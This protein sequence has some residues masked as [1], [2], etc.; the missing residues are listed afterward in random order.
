MIHSVNPVKC[1]PASGSHRDESG[2][3]AQSNLITF[4]TEFFV[5]KQ[6]AATAK[7]GSRARQSRCTRTGQ[8]SLTR[9]HHV[10]ACSVAPWFSI[11]ACVAVVTLLPG[12]LGSW[13]HQ[14]WPRCATP[15]TR[16]DVRNLRYRHAGITP[17][18]KADFRTVMTYC[19]SALPQRSCTQCVSTLVTRF[20]HFRK[21]LV[22]AVSTHL[23]PLQCHLSVA[24]ICPCTAHTS[25]PA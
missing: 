13:E 17:N 7:P 15:A 10:G 21:Q 8:A 2:E 22:D 9:I 6:F 1:D 11:G 3:L 18:F 4:A 23:E 25:W 12:A 16:R 5:L 24:S 20:D 19:G 14:A